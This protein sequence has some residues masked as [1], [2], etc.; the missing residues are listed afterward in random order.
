VL[1]AIGTRAARQTLGGGLLLAG[2][3]RIERMLGRGGVAT[4]QL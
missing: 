3:Y 2:R 1:V 4:V